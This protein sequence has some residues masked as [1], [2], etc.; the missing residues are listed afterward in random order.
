[1]K[2]VSTPFQSGG[3]PN[4]PKHLRDLKNL[5]LHLMQVTNVTPRRI[6]ELL[7]GCQVESR[8]SRRG[9]CGRR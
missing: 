2:Q 6:S 3:Q 7:R 9:N 1:M 5:T 4:E 8:F